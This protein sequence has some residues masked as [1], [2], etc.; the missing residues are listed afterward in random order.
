[1]KWQ[2]VVSH[3]F[4]LL[5]DVSFL[6]QTVTAGEREQLVAW[7]PFESVNVFR[8]AQ[9]GL[10]H[11]IV[12]FFRLDLHRVFEVTVVAE[13]VGEP[14]LGRELDYLNQSLNHLCVTLTPQKALKNAL[15]EI[16]DFL[17][18]LFILALLFAFLS[19]LLFLIF[20][21]LFGFLD[22]VIFH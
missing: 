12:D 15:L 17:V 19:L 21:W 16:F 6:E 20:A 1:M 13:K 18:L 7:E 9:E 8:A 14:M 11:E 22:C 10:G 3:F 4:E 2:L 5:S